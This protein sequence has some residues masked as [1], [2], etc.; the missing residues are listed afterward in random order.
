LFLTY[1]SGGVVFHFLSLLAD[2]NCAIK[3][4]QFDIFCSTQ[5]GFQ[6]VHQG[7]QI[8]TKIYNIHFIFARL[9]IKAAA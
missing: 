9:A 5:L 4:E 2:T 7:L 1:I 8:G 3:S 6:K